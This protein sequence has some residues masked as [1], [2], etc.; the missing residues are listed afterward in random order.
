MC[1]GVDAAFFLA[2]SGRERKH[3]TM[4]SVAFFSLHFALRVKKMAPLQCEALRF[5]VLFIKA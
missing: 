1:G 3:A 5:Q 2:G 4:R